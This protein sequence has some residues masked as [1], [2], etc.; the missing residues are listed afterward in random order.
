MQEQLWQGKCSMPCC[1]PSASRCAR[2]GGT[3]PAVNPCPSSSTESSKNAAAEG[4]SLCARA[5]TTENGA[6]KRDSLR[7]SFMQGQ[8]SLAGPP[9]LAL[10]GSTR[11]HHKWGHCRAGH[12]VALGTLKL[13]GAALAEAQQSV[14]RRGWGRHKASD[15]GDAGLAQLAAMV[16][17]LLERAT[18]SSEGSGVQKENIRYG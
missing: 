15:L 16:Q 7:P 17:P 2:K 10:T 11:V 18:V 14:L 12:L 1:A 8:P 6:V 5:C 3:V 13:A 9:L 4:C